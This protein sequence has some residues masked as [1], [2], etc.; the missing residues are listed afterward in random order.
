MPDRNLNVTYDIAPFDDQ[1]FRTM[2]TANNEV[3]QAQSFLQ[4][5]SRLSAEEEDDDTLEEDAYQ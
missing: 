1:R 5:K 3:L 2:E 4:L